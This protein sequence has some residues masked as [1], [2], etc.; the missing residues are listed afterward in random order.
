MKN[1]L[2]DVLYRDLDV[3]GLKNYIDHITKALDYDKKFN[4]ST[5]TNMKRLNAAFLVLNLKQKEAK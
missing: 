1:K 2:V 5:R 3:R 4:R